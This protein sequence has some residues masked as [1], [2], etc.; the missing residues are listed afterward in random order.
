MTEQLKKIVYFW[1]FQSS[2]LCRLFFSCDEQ[3]LLSSYGA[4]ASLVVEHRALGRVDLV[5]PAPRLKSTCL[6]VVVPGLSCSAACGFCPAEGLHRV[7][8]ICRWSLYH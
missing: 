7:S 5:I 6:V 3:G 2:L 1:F 8:C 4:W